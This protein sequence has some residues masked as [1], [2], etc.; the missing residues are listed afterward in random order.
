[1]KK[2]VLVFPCGTEI[3]NEVLA[4]L[5]NNKIFEVVLASSEGLSYCS[6]RNKEINFLPYVTEES[7]RDSIEDLS[8]KNNIEFIIPAHDDVAY[9]LSEIEST[10][11]AKV[12]GQ[13]HEFNK[14]ARFK[15]KTYQVCEKILPVGKVY[16]SINDVKNLPV[17]VKPK[18]GQGSSDAFPLETS[19]EVRFFKSNYNS[20]DFV[21]MELFTG[22]EYTIDCFSHN[23]E[24]LFAGP[25]TRDKAIKGISVLSKL[26]DDEEQLSQFSYYARLIS[27]KFALHGLWFFQMKK[28][29]D[30][31]L[32]LL[33]LAPRVSGTMMVNRAKGINFVEL[34]LYQAQGYDVETVFNQIHVSIARSLVPTYKHSYEFNVL[35]IDFDDTLLIDEK[36]INTDLIKLIFQCKNQ[37]KDVCLI[38]K[39]KKNNLASTL[40]R[41]GISNVF[42]EIIHL[43]ECDY[44]VDYMLS[45]SMLIDD[46]FQERKQAIKS[47]HFSLGTDAIKVLLLP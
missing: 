43:K 4:S 15:D 30:G 42:K 25:R 35:Y 28:A 27:T 5:E 18:K 1:M 3:A 34:A 32:K 41:F 46:S 9:K 44:K 39:N 8:L 2:K 24:L 45:N 16:K 36:N 38:T 26:V 10:L 12:I 14:V 19:E 21:V 6:F 29:Q 40:H 7:F 31:S 22:E 37:E 47:G 23:G 11:T 33:E 17:F 13:S 20:N